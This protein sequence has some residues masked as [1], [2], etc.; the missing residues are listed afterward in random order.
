M[1]INPVL[2]IL[3]SQSVHE[4][5]CQRFSQFTRKERTVVDM[6]KVKFG[7]INIVFY[8]CW[9]PNLVNGVI[10]WTQWYNLP[11]ET[12]Y[13]LWYFMVR[14]LIIF[15]VCVCVLSCGVVVE[16]PKNMLKR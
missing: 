6:F 9:L 11:R 1:A 3:S 12:M 2:Y 5:V 7:V 14:T 8:M 15:C 16:F 13:A 10:L 4:L